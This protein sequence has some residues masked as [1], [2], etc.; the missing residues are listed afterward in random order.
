MMKMIIK[1]TTGSSV[2]VWRCGRWEMLMVC[3]L[4]AVYQSLTSAVFKK[5]KWL[6]QN[7]F[8]YNP[9]RDSRKLSMELK[10]TSCPLLCTFP[11]SLQST[12]TCHQR[13]CLGEVVA[14]SLSC[15]NFGVCCASAPYVVLGP[16]DSQ[17][18]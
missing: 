10:H 5:V 11:L 4:T 2:Y 9:C 18:L 14:P 12:H 15:S 13:Q 6:S 7:M 17:P 1:E 3:G 8:I 16:G